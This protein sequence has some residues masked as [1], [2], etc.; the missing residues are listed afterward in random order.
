MNP[1]TNH[2]EIWPE[3]L[4][5]TKARVKIFSILED[6]HDPMSAMEIFEQLKKSE[7]AIWLSTVYRVLE[8]F[9]EK[10]MVIKITVLNKENAL[11]E[12]NHFDHRHYAICLGCHKMVTMENCPMDQFHPQFKDNQFHV[13]DHKLEFYGYCKNCDKR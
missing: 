5:K 9:V 8:T 12:I 1:V 7:E 4:K 10:G 11:Y 2:K 6:A 3:G 13:V